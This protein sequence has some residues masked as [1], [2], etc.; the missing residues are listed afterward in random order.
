VYNCNILANDD[1][2][3]CKNSSGDTPLHDA[4]VAFRVSFARQLLFLGADPAAKN[5]A[6]KSPQSLARKLHGAQAAEMVSVL[7]QGASGFVCRR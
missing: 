7:K 3:A 1:V 2:S 6:G 4:V 5:K